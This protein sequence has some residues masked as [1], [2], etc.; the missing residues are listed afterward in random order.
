ML[1][2]IGQSTILK[3]KGESKMEQTDPTTLSWAMEEYVKRYGKGTVEIDKLD[4][5]IRELKEKQS[6]KRR[7]K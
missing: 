4:E 3:G 5:I 2:V 1:I 6:R 7:K